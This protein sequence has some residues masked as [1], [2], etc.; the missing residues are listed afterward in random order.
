[1]A[2]TRLIGEY[3]QVASLII[4][5]PRDYRFPDLAPAA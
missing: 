1:M 5:N 3:T 2:P 4:V